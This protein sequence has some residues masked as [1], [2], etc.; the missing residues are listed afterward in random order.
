MMID[1]RRDR[2]WQYGMEGKWCV[3]ARMEW[4]SEWIESIRCFI[5]DGIFPL[6]TSLFVYLLSA[7]VA[8]TENKYLNTGSAFTLYIHSQRQREKEFYIC[9]Y[10]YLLMINMKISSH[11]HYYWH[12]FW[13]AFTIKLQFRLSFHPFLVLFGSMFKYA[14]SSIPWIFHAATNFISAFMRLYVFVFVCTRCIEPFIIT[15]CMLCKWSAPIIIQ[16][17]YYSGVGHAQRN[18]TIF[19]SFMPETNG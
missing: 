4:V 13:I 2:A 17:T 16:T 19:A 12:I 6:A 10:V 5:D 8:T 3:F 1:R 9:I 15:S 7:T 18:Q 11:Y 14:A